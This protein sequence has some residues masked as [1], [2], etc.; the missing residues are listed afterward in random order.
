MAKA[1]TVATALTAIGQT[2]ALEHAVNPIKI[3]GSDKLLPQI[4]QMLNGWAKAYP[5][6]LKQLPVEADIPEYIASLGRMPMASALD[7]AIGDLSLVTFYYLLQI[8]EYT[9]KRT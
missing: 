6:T 4:Q 2:I 9:S 5:P 3:S 1:A 7:Q 8:G